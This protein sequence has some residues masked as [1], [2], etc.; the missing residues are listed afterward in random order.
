MRITPVGGSDLLDGF[1]CDKGQFGFQYVSS[2]SRLKAPLIKKN[3]SFIP[4]SYDDAL[5]LIVS[6]FK[7]RVSENGADSVGG[8]V[9]A[10]SSCEEIYLFQKLF[11]EGFG[12]NNIDFRMNI[13]HNSGEVGSVLDGSLEYSHLATS[14]GVFVFG[15]NPLEEQPVLGAYLRNRAK[16]K[17]T[18]LFVA[19]PLRTGLEDCAEFSVRYKP[20]TEV[21][22]IYGIISFIWNAGMEEKLSQITGFREFKQQVERN[23]LERIEEI[24]GVS[25]EII[26]K[27][28]AALL[29]RNS[30]T[31]ITNGEKEDLLLSAHNLSLF[32]KNAG[33]KEIRSGI[34]P[35]FPQ[36]N[37]R[38]AMKLISGN[39]NTGKIIDDALSGKLKALYILHSD[40]VFEFPD[41]GKIKAALKNLEFLVVQDIFLT[42]TAEFAD[43][44]LPG[45]SP[46][47]KDGSFVCSGGMMQNLQAGIKEDVADEW[48]TIT[49]ISNGIGYPMKYGSI[50]EIRNEITPILQKKESGGEKFAPV[51]F[52]EKAEKLPYTL[53]EEKNMFA[54]NRFILH[55]NAINAFFKPH[56][57]LNPSDAGNLG[58]HQGDMVKIFNGKGE[59]TIQV[60][61]REDVPPGC[62]VMTN[63]IASPLNILTNAGEEITEVDIRKI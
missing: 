24:T 17:N 37:Y 42:E 22:L 16:T 10:G 28:S 40:P 41:R 20:G 50:D 18:A 62:I 51:S 47:A 57:V 38:G 1:L 3:G 6:Q 61:I 11:K 30:L 56:A 5:N 27:I 35:I 23:K 44:V 26:R 46:H 32:L 15:V 49:H 33:K 9:S 19:H 14:D 36:P 25:K 29:A 39:F 13:P 34:L 31:I 52:S 45:K 12:S 8:I 21:Y 53:L 7:K 58:L 43:V 4:S 63:D 59:L 60:S 55:C 54:G 48:K 2:G